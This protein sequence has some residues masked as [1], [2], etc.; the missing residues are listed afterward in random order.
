MPAV[1]E[2]AYSMKRRV[3]SANVR[4]NSAAGRVACV[5]RRAFHPA[6]GAAYAPV[7]QGLHRRPSAPVLAL[8]RAAPGRHLGYGSACSSG[9]C[10]ASVQHRWGRRLSGCVDK[11]NRPSPLRFACVSCGF[12]GLADTIAAGVSARRAA[13]TQP[14]A[15]T[16]LASSLQALAFRRGFVTEAEPMLGAEPSFRSAPPGEG[17]DP[18]C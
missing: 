18:R 12:A 5:A 13:V 15:A 11:R 1:V 3:W 6:G 16:G 10:C 8:R 4:D 17:V 9:P 7:G 14:R 2:T